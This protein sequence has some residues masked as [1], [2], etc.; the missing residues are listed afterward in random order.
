MWGVKVA[1]GQDWDHKP[2]LQEYG[3]DMTEDQLRQGIN[4]AMDTMEQAQRNGE[5]VPQIRNR[6]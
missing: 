1:P 5:N 4:D 2:Q 3:D 6:K